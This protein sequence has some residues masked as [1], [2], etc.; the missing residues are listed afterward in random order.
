MHQFLVQT[1]AFQTYTVLSEAAAGVS[2]RT[3][4]YFI[5]TNV[6]VYRTYFFNVEKSIFESSSRRH[7]RRYVGFT[8]YEPPETQG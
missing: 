4:D 8:R 6:S 3:N 1:I 5:L 2:M 7:E